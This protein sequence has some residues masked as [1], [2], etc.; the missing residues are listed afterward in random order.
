MFHLV[1]QRILHKKWMVASLLIGN[2]LLIAI[3]VSNPMY[4]DATR[5]RMLTDQFANYLEANNTYPMII[6]SEGLVR[7]KGGRG[8]ADKLTEFVNAIPYSMKL[9]AVADVNFLRMI[10]DDALS[11]NVHK[12]NDAQKV[13]IGAL[14]DLEDH[15]QAL[16]G[17]MPSKTRTAD[18][19]IEAAIS[20]GAM[21]RLN[22]VVGEELE[23][24]N[25][26]YTKEETVKVR[27][28]GIYTY[29]DAADPYWTDGPD[30]YSDAVMMDY[31]LFLELFASGSKVEFQY[32]DVRLLL[33]DYNQ[34]RPENA[35]D[36]LNKTKEMTAAYD[37]IYSS[38]PEPDYTALIEKFL[39]EENRIVTTLAI[40]QVPVLVLLCAFIFMIS[41][42]MLEMEEN[43]IALLKSRGA[44]KKQVITMYLYQSLVLSGISFLLGIPLGALVCKILGASSAF[45]KF[46]SPRSLKVELTKE[47][48]VYAL[49]AVAASMLM[50]LLP[51]FKRDKVS[52]VAVKRKKSRSDKPLWK[53]L[54]LDFI[55]L[56]VSLYGLYSFSSR[57]DELLL[58]VLSGQSLDPLLFLSSSL[59]ILGAGMISLRI[60]NLLV[61]VIYGV[62]KKGWKPAE[63]TSFLQLIRTGNKQAFIMVFLVLTVAFGMFNTTVA[64]TILANAENNTEYVYGADIIEQE[65][66]KNN[67]SFVATDPTLELV[68]TEPDFTK[69]LGLNAKGVAKVFTN[70]KVV[71]KLS[72]SKIDSG[73]MGIDTK[74]FGQ[75]AR[76]KEGLLKYNF[77]EYLNVL[78]TNPDAVLLS[79][80]YRD[81]HG[82]KLGDRITYSID[83]GAIQGTNTA[84]IYGF[85]DYWPGYRPTVVNVMEDN[86]TSVEEKYLIVAHLS[87]IQ[88]KIGVYPYKVWIN[89]NGNTENFYN[90]ANEQKMSITGMSDAVRAKEEIA[91]EPLFQGTNGILTMSFI[92]VLLI[93]AIGYVIYWMLS[94]KSRELLFGIFR[95]MGMSRSEVIRMLINEQVFT[96]VFGIAFGLLIG[97]IASVLYVPIIQIA[98][99]AS[100][101][102]LP[103]ELI[104]KGSD[105]VRLLIIIALMFAVCLFILINQVFK[106]KIS[107]ALKLGED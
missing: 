38:I 27:I 55:L 28:V 76:M 105:I 42:Q 17:N 9:D 59:F 50:T 36:V 71:T 69:Y 74:S 62:G 97:Y 92:T 16:S 63:Y 10:P 99:S 8:A 37:S 72:D 66:W 35:A 93:C 15:A 58:R 57:Q 20:Q 44:S 77:N 88:E 54:Y 91:S 1:L 104:T 61:K 79:S 11:L 45:L 106:M 6:R 49:I 34:L 41:R 82:L 68:Y 51:V 4:Q 43:E 107:Q 12:G 21:V 14:R 3:A 80:N 73:I 65:Y 13:A 46:D 67:A 7:K 89:M 40:L 52:I 98:Y 90:F 22:L 83:D 48:F 70:D 32:N 18:G 87:T 26:H 64:R 53:K 84:V 31:D 33:L 60:Q 24:K 85:F 47:V 5:R 29:S 30:T 2:I 75:T 39:G 96:G 86:S 95:A 78:S 94:I 19:F 23:F 100:D 56:G 101:R 81:K 102:V 103:L 25:L